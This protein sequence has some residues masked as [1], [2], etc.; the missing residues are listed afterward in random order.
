MPV[1]DGTLDPR[2]LQGFKYFSWLDD[3]LVRLRPAAT[4][5][6]SAGNRR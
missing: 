1:R 6:D 2:K 5:S 4:E 3:L